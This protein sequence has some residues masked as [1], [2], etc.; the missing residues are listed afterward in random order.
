MPLRGIPE[1]E[2]ANSF[3]SCDS[4]FTSG[5]DVHP[6]QNIGI[7]Q[8]RCLGN[9]NSW[10]SNGIRSDNVDQISINLNSPVYTANVCA[11]DWDESAGVNNSLC[12]GAVCSTSIPDGDERY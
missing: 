3:E 4:E 10:E 2:L 8:I 1:R 7:P 9:Y 6:N 5:D 11:T 12:N